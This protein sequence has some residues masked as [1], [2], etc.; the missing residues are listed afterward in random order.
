M[1]VELQINCYENSFV[2][3]VWLFIILILNVKSIIALSVS[4]VGCSKITRLSLI[5]SMAF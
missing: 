4:D 1:V 5:I 3:R 2:S